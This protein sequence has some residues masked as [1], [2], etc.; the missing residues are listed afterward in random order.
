MARMQ[1]DAECV[2]VCLLSAAP[3]FRQITDR[4]HNMNVTEDES[5]I[6]NCTAYAE[7]EA[8]VQWFKNG[9]PLQRKSI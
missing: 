6:I 5:V 4:P 3:V 1:A 2:A 9:E 7:P 8:N